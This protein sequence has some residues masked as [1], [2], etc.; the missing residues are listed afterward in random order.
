MG[1]IGGVQFEASKFKE[2]KSARIQSPPTPSSCN[3]LVQAHITSPWTTAI[4]PD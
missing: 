4:I 3:M 2:L 1:D